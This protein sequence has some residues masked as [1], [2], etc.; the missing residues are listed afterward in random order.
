M[1]NLPNLQI[2][3]DILAYWYA[4][5]KRYLENNRNV[6]HSPTNAALEQKREEATKMAERTVSILKDYIEQPVEVAVTKKGE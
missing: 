2:P 3:F 5:A 1:S 6:N 4:S